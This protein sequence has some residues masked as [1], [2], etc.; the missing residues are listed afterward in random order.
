MLQS[1]AA[2]IDQNQHNAQKCPRC[3][4][5]IYLVMVVAHTWFVLS[6]HES[7]FSPLGCKYNFYP[8]KPLVRH[9][10]RGLVTG[11]ASLVIPV[12][13]VGAVALLAVGT[14]IGAPT[15]GTYR[16]VKHIHSKRQERRQRYRMKTIARHWNTSDSLLTD[17]QMIESD[18]IRKAVQANLMTRREEI[19][20]RE[21]TPYPT[22]NLDHSNQNNDD[23]D[24]DS[25]DD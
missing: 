18:D 13:A 23:D 15:Y 19:A 14:T 6:S 20:G 21:L 10:V 16:L 17:D 3:K 4:I 22:R 1:W 11:A 8:D 7:R 12:A 9:T 24:E 5:Y 2:Q 25:F